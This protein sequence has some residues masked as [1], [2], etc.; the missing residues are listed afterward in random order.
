MLIQEILFCL[1][2]EVPMPIKVLARDVY[3]DVGDQI[4]DERRLYSMIT[5][6][7]NLDWEITNQTNAFGK[8]YLISKRHLKLLKMAFC[9]PDKIPI[10]E[11]GKFSVQNVIRA[12]HLF[13]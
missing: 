12:I 2:S 13:S 11:I 5:Q 1:N 8:G 9:G 4:G 3:E 6:V 10:D 7:K